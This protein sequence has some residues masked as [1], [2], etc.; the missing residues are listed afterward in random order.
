MAKKKK[1]NKCE[2]STFTGSVSG[3]VLCL[4]FG[5]IIGFIVPF[6]LWLITINFFLKSL[7]Y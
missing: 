7:M 2:N 3:D 4:I 1:N 5:V 6:I